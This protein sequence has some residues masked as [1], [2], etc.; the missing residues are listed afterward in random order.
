MTTDQESGR[1][2]WFDIVLII[3]V[4]AGVFVATG[5]LLWAPAFLF[6]FEGS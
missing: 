6:F 1:T 3:I 5:L 2:R 4:A